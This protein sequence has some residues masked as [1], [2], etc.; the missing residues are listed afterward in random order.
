MTGVEPPVGGPI[1]GTEG[2]KIHRVLSGHSAVYIVMSGPDE[3]VLIDAGMEEDAGNLRATLAELG[4]QAV[5]AIFVTHAHMDHVAGLH[6]F[7]DAD[8]Y[9]HEAEFP[10]LRGETR[11]HGFVGLMAGKLPTA[12]V[13]KQERLRAVEDG[14][15]ITIGSATITAYATPG[16]TEG[17]MSYQ[18]GNVV[19]VGDLLFVDPKGNVQLPPRMITPDPEVATESIKQL[20]RRTADKGIDIVLPSHSG[21]GTYDALRSFAEK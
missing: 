19:C 4:V 7:G 10:F 3:A 5:K 11:G 6:E 9:A 18:A 20:A 17:S 16:H 13:V 12:D 8:V 15:S 2:V 21:A 14:Q 1:A